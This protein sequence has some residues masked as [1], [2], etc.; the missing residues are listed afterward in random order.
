MDFERNISSLRPVGR[1]LA[2]LYIARLYANGNDS[3]GFVWRLW[4]PLAWVLIPLAIITS[5]LIVGIPET[6]S[7]K[8]NLGLCVDPWFEKNPEQLKWI[9]SRLVPWRKAYNHV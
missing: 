9:P 5:I 3:V 2:K 1:I 7:D 4:N 8:S 6:F